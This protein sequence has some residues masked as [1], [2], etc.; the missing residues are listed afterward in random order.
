[1]GRYDQLPGLRRPG[2]ARPP[3]LAR[4]LPPIHHVHRGKHPFVRPCQGTCE[5]VITRQ[6]SVVGAHVRIASSR[7]K[8]YRHSPGRLEHDNRRDHRDVLAR[9]CPSIRGLCRNWRGSLRMAL[10]ISSAR[11]SMG[12]TLR[13]ARGS[14]HLRAAR[15]CSRGSPCSLR[16]PDGPRRGVDNRLAVRTPSARR[17]VDPRG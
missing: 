7:L 10:S 8:E 17:P 12:F 14:V 4:V 5:G 11:R 6:E 16:G 3:L 9:E 13:R 2:R 15:P 1:M